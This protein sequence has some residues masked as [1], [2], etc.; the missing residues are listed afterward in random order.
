MAN[1]DGLHPYVKEKT[2]QL[3]KN[4]NSRLKNYKMIITQ[5]YRSTEEQNKLYAKGRTVAP[6]GKKYIVTNAKG[7]TSMHNFGLAIDF[8]LVDPTGKKVVWDDKTDFDR[9]G[10]VDWMEVVAEAKKLGFAWG[11]DFKTFVDKPHLQMLG[12][13]TEKEVISGKKPVFVQP[14]VHTVVK[15]DTVSEIAEHYKVTVEQ[16]KK[17]NKDIDINVIH[18]GQKIRVK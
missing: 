9:D 12:G 6:I 5:A 8:A 7:G 16:I 14:T 4:A 3:L 13:L 18:L 17:L 2:E 10:Q 15:G 11:G 1:L